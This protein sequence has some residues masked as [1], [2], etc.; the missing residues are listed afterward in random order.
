[1]ARHGY[2]QRNG[3]EAARGSPVS[4]NRHTLVDAIGVAADD[5]VLTG[6]RVDVLYEINLHSRACSMGIWIRSP[7]L[8]VE[9]LLLLFLLLGKFHAAKWRAR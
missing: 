3:Q 5:V 7:G 6:C 1:M 4:T 2:A 9:L 8:L